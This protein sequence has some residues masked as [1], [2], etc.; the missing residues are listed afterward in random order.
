MR[1]ILSANQGI[2]ET[3]YQALRDPLGLYLTIEGVEIKLARSWF[4]K[5]MRERA[6]EF[7]NLVLVNTGIALLIVNKAEIERAKVNRTLN[8]PHDPFDLGDL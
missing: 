7:D 2:L 4:Y 5:V 3:L 1:L 6:P 8:A